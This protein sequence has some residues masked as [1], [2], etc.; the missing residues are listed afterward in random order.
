[1]HQLNKVQ[2]ARLQ[3]FRN[4]HIEYPGTHTARAKIDDLR[5]HGRTDAR[6]AR[7]AILFGPTG[8]GKSRCIE[9]YV[10]I[11]NREARKAGARIDPVKKIELPTKCTS[12][13]LNELLLRD[14]GSA[15]GTRETTAMSTIRAANGIIEQGW[16]LIILD[17][18]QHLIVHNTPS[19]A[20]EAS[21]HCKQLLNAAG[22]PIL[23]VGLQNVEE[24]LHSN[25]QLKRRSAPAIVL[26]A[27]DFEVPEERNTF[28]QIL[29]KFDEALP[30]DVPAALDTLELAKR[31][32]FATGGV[33]GEVSRLLLD[34]SLIGIQ[35]SARTLDLN[36]LSEAFEG[37]RLTGDSRK[38]NPFTA[39]KLPL[40]SKP[41]KTSHGTLE[42]KKP[43]R[44]AS[45]Q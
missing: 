1:M 42:K 2:I 20:F 36:H 17:E 9:A 26:A 5:I 38:L 27:F 35:R 12:K 16:E 14:L 4:L 40:I 32:H 10:E 41:H 24:I 23:F 3:T 31:V 15:M 18:A 30:F 6:E 11:A 34:A 25:M 44:P 33:I 22:C 21:D 29:Q 13:T 8:A 19:A 43:G 37:Y 39:D 28:R 45:P 7:C